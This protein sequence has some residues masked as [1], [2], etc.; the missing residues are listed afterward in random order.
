M[1]DET[2]EHGKILRARANEAEAKWRAA[3]GI[4]EHLR[5]KKKFRGP[6]KPK[7]KLERGEIR[8][9]DQRAERRMLARLKGV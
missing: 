2:D 5:T 4:D 3:H 1:K 8:R 7:R 9:R 6:K